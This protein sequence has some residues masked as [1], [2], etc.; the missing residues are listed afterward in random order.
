MKLKIRN[1][2]G[3]EEAD[4]TFKPLTLIQGENAQGKSSIADAIRVA[5]GL[6]VRG[7]L[8]KDKKSLTRIGTDRWEVILQLGN[9]SLKASTS[10]APRMSIVEGAVGVQK[11]ILPYCL[12]ADLFLNTTPKELQQLLGE[13]FTTSG[14]KDKLK[15]KG[16]PEDYIFQLPESPKKAIKFAEDQRAENRIQEPTPPEDIEVK[17]GVKAS[18][19]DIKKM[20]DKI[21]ELRKELNDKI[22]LHGA[23]LLGNKKDK[24]KILEKVEALQKEI[25]EIEEK[26]QEKTRLEIEKEKIV[27]KIDELDKQTAPTHLIDK[28]I[29]EKIRS[30]ICKRCQ[31]KFDALINQ[32]T[33]NK[34]IEKKIEALMEQGEEIMKKIKAIE[35]PDN[36]EEKKVELKRLKEDLKEEEETQMTAEEFEELKKEID[37]L[38]KRITTGRKIRDVVFSYNVKLQDY[39]SEMIIYQGKKEKWELWDK[40][41][42]T[43]PEAVKE[44]QSKDR[45]GLRDLL[46]QQN[47]LEGEVDITDDF[48]IVY[49]DLPI[50]FLSDTERYR[51]C[52]VVYNAILELY[53]FPFML[54]DRGEILITKELKKALLTD[55]LNISKHRTVIFIQARPRSEVIE[56]SKSNDRIASYL[57]EKGKV[58]E[59]V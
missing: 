54:I 22:A 31:P 8:Q 30:V 7:I 13:M 10:L 28:D 40:V 38:D 41:A 14:W 3:I 51:V 16:I 5:F 15:E 34:E 58:N 25:E 21:Q 50:S 35:I 55:L 48:R 59:V 49:N 39:N 57:V 23:Y 24:D 1:F 12:D 37:A 44:D 46:K 29:A 20:D 11:R 43:I 17:K 42:K 4:I 53:N 19:C 56:K 52:L 33:D 18:Q 6:S 9:A 27:N 36:Y 26:K 47:I 32:K 45:E 2:L